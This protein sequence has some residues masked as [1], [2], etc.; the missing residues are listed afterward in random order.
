MPK[1]QI[2]DS[3]N[4]CAKL[5]IDR[6]FM[7]VHKM[8]IDDGLSRCGK[9]TINR[10]IARRCQNCKIL[11]VLTLAQN[12]LRFNQ[13][14]KTYNRPIFFM[15]ICKMRIVDGLNR[16]GTLTINQYIAGKCQICKLLTVRTLAQNFLQFK[17]M[18]KTYNRPFFISRKYAK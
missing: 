7:E 8:R 6:F 5:T 9:L 18:R 16:C 14:R 11:T 12:F 10:S 15:E 2:I 4:S 13:L 3:L 1:L 17:Q